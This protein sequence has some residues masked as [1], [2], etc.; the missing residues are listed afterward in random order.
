[1]KPATLFSTVAIG[2][3]TA[4]IVAAGGPAMAEPGYPSWS[5]IEQA[6]QNE[7]TKQAEI[8]RVTGLLAG[9]QQAEDAAVQTSMIA[10]EA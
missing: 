3:V 8:A 1:M 9:L 4:S 7:Q 2:A 10:D 6:K 5:D